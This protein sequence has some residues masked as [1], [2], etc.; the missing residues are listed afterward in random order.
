MTISELD[1]Q[2]VLVKALARRTYEL[3]LQGLEKA[4]QTEEMP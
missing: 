2:D 3:D 4:E 1:L